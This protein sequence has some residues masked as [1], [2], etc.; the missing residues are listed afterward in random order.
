NNFYLY[1]GSSGTGTSSNNTLNLKIKMSGKASEVSYF[2]NMNF[3]LSGNITNGDTMLETASVTY[4]NTTV[5][6]VASN[7]VSLKKDDVIYL[8]KADSASGSI[9]ND[10]ASVLGG[11]ATVKLDGNNLIL[12]LLQDLSDTG[13]KD[14]QKAPVEGIAAAVQTVNMIADLVSGE[15]MNSLLLETTDGFTNTFGAFTKSQSKYKTGSHVDVDGWGILVGTGNTKK[16]QD[17]SATAYGLFFE[18]GKGDF[19]TYNGNVHGD[20]N[21]ENKGIGIMARHKLTNNTYYEGNIRFGK[22]ETKWSQSELGG[23]D[24]DSRY[25]GI[26]VGVGHIYPVGKNEIDVYGRYTYGHVGACDATLKDSKY[27]FDSVKSHRVRVGGK[28]NFKVKD[29]NAKPF[30]GL[31]WEHEFK[32]ESK[33]SISGV[34]EAPAPSMKG[35]TGIFELGCDW[36]VSKKWTLGLGANAYMGKRKGWDGTAR[37]FY[38]F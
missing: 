8:V 18:Y 12:T 27:H 28:Y 1:G 16:W 2:Q 33:A 6:V 14:Q 30:I 31:A 24:T 23:Y 15:G 36:D 25:Y 20:G 11:A 13:S 35:H 38:N 19:D 32:G 34:G 21:S 22:Q 17:G 4:D 10:G 7:S 26:S 5:G 37:V 29:S 3:T 9:S